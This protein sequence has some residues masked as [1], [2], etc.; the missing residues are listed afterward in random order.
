MEEVVE[1]V[2]GWGGEGQGEPVEDGAEEIEGEDDGKPPGPDPTGAEVE[3]E[4]VVE[5]EGDMTIGE[6]FLTTIAALM[7]D[8]GRRRYPTGLSILIAT[9][10]GVDV[11]GDGDGDG[12]VDD[13]DDDVVDDGDS[14]VA[15][16]TTPD[17]PPPR[18]GPSLYTFCPV[19]GCVCVGCVGV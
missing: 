18:Y 13:D 8:G 2:G 6:P 3:V 11:D 12:D 5:V 7:I 10:F 15:E 1:V 14:D 17:T 19:C 9:S 4:V 16:Y